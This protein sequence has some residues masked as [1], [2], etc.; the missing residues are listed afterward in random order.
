MPPEARAP[1]TVV[2]AA[3]PYAPA[4]ADEVFRALAD[5]TRRQLLDA[6][7][8]TNGQSLQ[9]LC[10]GVH[11]AR[12]SVSKHLAVL[13]AADLVATV[14]RG[15]RK[16]HFL[17][18]VPINDLAE[19]WIDRFDRGRLEA[20]ADL[21][22]ALEGTTVTEPTPRTTEFVYVAYIRTTPEDLWRALTDP[23]FTR[24]WWQGTSVDSAWTPGSPMTWHHRG[25]AITHPDQVVLVADPP[26]RLS[27]TWHT[28]S[29]EWARAV[30]FDDGLRAVIEA[31][32]RSVATFDL[33]PAGE[34][35]KL[36]VTHSDLL[37][38]GTVRRLI[39]EGWPRVV[40]DLKSFVETGD[41]A[42]G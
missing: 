8:T 5:P 11:L 27:F 7:R 4:G 33:E 38:D 1:A 41:V 23:A 22:R 28:F 35:V 30:G 26:R 16:L 13:E 36:T 6:L 37:V 2:T 15:R 32:P 42:P 18:P 25:V 29:P 17:N 20:L 39:T 19:R 31:E 14:R 3:A 34:L 40:S 24:R 12:Q 9:E 10:A 21:R